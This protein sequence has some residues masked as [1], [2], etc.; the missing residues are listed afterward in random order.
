[1]SCVQQQHLHWHRFKM[2]LKRKKSSACTEHRHQDIDDYY[3]FSSSNDERYNDVSQDVIPP[4]ASLSPSSSH[5]SNFHCKED[6]PPK[7]F[8]SLSSQ[9]L[10]LS[11]SSSPQCFDA[12]METTRVHDEDLDEDDD[13]WKMS[14]VSLS[15]SLFSSSSS[16]SFPS[17]CSSSFTPHSLGFNIK[18]SLL[19]LLFSCFLSFSFHP[20]DTH[21]SS[22]SSVFV[23]AQYRPQWVDPMLSREIFVLN[24]EDGYFGCQVNDST[25]F[26]QL[27]EL[28]KLCDGSPQCFRGSDELSIH[29][30]CTDRNHCHPKMPNCANGVCLDGL[31]YC[32]DGFGGKGC[33]LPGKQTA[34]LDPYSVSFEKSKC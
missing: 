23:S 17:S 27:F 18:T 28:S 19:F 3:N 22:S 2:K 25:D 4:A 16:K 15:S 32:N 24:L 11:S 29:L 5:S 8:L 33:D 34:S 20:H 1:M 7:N 14:S 30:K 31:C 9:P 26:L 21:S 6:N 13:N 12:K 10:C